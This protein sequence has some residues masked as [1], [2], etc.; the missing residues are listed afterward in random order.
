[1]PLDT[2]RYKMNSGADALLGLADLLKGI[3]AIRQGMAQR[4]MN[5]RPIGEVLGYQGQP[6]PSVPNKM[7]T[8]PDMRPQFIRE[9][10]GPQVPIGGPGPMQF[11][12][13]SPAMQP[14]LRAKVG[15]ISGLTRNVGEGNMRALMSMLAPKTSFD[16]DSLFYNPGTK[17]FDLVPS[18]GAIKTS[19]RK[20]SII[21]G[22]T[23]LSE[24]IKNKE[25]LAAWRGGVEAR[26]RRGGISAEIKAGL[27]NDLDLL[28]LRLNEGFEDMDPAEQSFINSQIGAAL[29]RLQRYGVNPTKETT[30]QV[31]KVY[32]DKPKGTSPIINDPRQTRFNELKAEYPDMSDDEIMAL[33]AMEGVGTR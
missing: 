29:S 23:R 13:A 5:Q 22:Q 30:R 21:Q 18:P 28:D 12:G 27:K 25:R 24:D 16:E 31:D 6:G 3:G 33:Q 10:L 17:A 26:M 14:M 2:R 20:A 1:M 32:G 9:A 19:P 7:L 8:P 11:N 4:N 15:D